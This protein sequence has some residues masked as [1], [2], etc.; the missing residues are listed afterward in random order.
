MKKIVVFDF[1][2][3]I[4]TGISHYIYCTNIIADNLEPPDANAFLDEVDN[5]FS[6]K[7]PFI[8]EDGWDL[9]NRI[10]RKY[11]DRNLFEHS[12][13]QTRR[14]MLL[15]IHKGDLSENVISL[16]KD[17]HSL[18]TTALAS[19]SPEEYVKGYLDKLDLE[20]HFDYVRFSAK[21]PEGLID[22]V[23]SISMGTDPGDLKV[24]SVGDH[25]VNDI[26]PALR[27]KWDTAF[28]NPFHLDSRGSTVSGQSIS[29]LSEWI[30]SWCKM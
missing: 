20:K 17:V 12:F 14:H 7:K 6:G 24:L 9:L 30:V 2:G 28:I 1:D 22:L 11:S 25:Y 18:C 5:S 23:F 4:T 26:Q 16:L 8:G 3:T 29:D 15:N 21:K 19:N 27:M 13:H 10:S